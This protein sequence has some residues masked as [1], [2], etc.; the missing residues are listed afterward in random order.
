M[1]I[2]HFTYRIKTKPKA[3]DIEY[4]DVNL[5][6]EV[7]DE[8]EH[9]FQPLTIDHKLALGLVNGTRQLVPV[10]N[11]VILTYIPK[12]NV[13]QYRQY[14][15]WIP[16]AQG[17]IQQIRMLQLGVNNSRTTDDYLLYQCIEALDNFWD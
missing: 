13:Y 6:F 17:I 3:T 14:I 11:E 2:R 4:A 15:S 9:L 10:S 7:E 16:A 5:I 12:F 8:L 1:K